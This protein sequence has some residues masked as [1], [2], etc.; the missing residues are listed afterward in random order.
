MWLLH[1]GGHG[2]LIVTLVGVSA[3]AAI[4]VAVW[5]V[6]RHRSALLEERRRLNFEADLEERHRRLEGDGP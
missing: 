2:V 1:L 5:T 3:Y 6:T 4:N